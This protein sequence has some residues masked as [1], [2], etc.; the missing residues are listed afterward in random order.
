M[1]VLV[2]AGS[3]STTSINKQLAK[4]AANQLENAQLIVLDLNDFEMAIYSP[5]REKASGIPQQATDFLQHISQ[6][7]FIVT[8]MAENNANFS[9]A[10]KNV[11]DWCS[12]A[13]KVV[14]Q[15]KPMLLMATSPGA[16]GGMNVLE[17]A[18]NTFS[19]FGAEVKATFSLPSFYQNFDT[20]NQKITEENLDNKLKEIIKSL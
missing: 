8:S 14:F 3:N 5:E 19:R 7:D 16:R 15:N 10:F 4:Y 2:F 9:A 20:E 1:K 13:E 12:R 17:I 6:C 11:F 18:N